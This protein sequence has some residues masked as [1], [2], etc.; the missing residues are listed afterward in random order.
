LG[1]VP[2]TASDAAVVTSKWGIGA[3]KGDEMKDDSST[4]NNI[5]HLPIEMRDLGGRIGA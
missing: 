2:D 3:K 4:F 1:Q 5:H